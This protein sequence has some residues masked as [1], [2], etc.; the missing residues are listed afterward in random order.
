MVPLYKQFKEYDSVEVRLETVRWIN[1][2]NHRKLVEQYSK[3]K[4]RRKRE[5]RLKT[6]LGLLK[7]QN[8]IKN[9]EE[10]L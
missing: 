5:R 10:N 4:Y 2:H 7:V 9:F 8:E 3:R 1:D 6:E